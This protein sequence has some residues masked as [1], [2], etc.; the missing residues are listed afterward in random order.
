MA[1]YPDIGL[2]AEIQHINGPR[3]DLSE[4]GTFRT[5]DLTTKNAYRVQLVHPLLT[6]SEVDTLEAFYAANK[7]GDV[8]ITLFGKSYTL[9][10][11]RG[12]TPRSI[13]ATRTELSVS[14]VGNRT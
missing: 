1:A 4:A 7:G 14:L 13:S 12:Y 10:F 5:L 3:S 8:T 11:E 2:Q 6:A 9:R